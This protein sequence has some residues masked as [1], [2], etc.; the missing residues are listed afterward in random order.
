M[1]LLADSEG[2]DQTVRMRS[3]I[4]AFAV[5]ICLKTYFHMAWPSMIYNIQDFVDQHVQASSVVTED[6][7]LFL[8]FFYSLLVLY[9]LPVS[10]GKR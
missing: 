3:L 4:W 7:L 10:I 2:P 9:F 5:R 6:K 8:H 1:I